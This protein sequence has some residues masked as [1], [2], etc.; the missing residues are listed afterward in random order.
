MNTRVQKY[1]AWSI[2]PFLGFYLF[3]F[4]WVAGFQPPPSPVLTGAQLSQ[5]YQQ[6]HND[7]LIGQL[8][9]IL[10][11]GLMLVWPAAVS[12]Q[13]ARIEQ[14]SF[15]L[16]SIIQYVSA[17]VLFTLFLL[18]GVIWSVAAFRPDISPDLLRLL[19]DS[20]WL[21][22]VMGYPEYVVQLGCIAIV[23]LSDRRAVPFLPRWAC[24]AMLGTAFDGCGGVFSALT[25]SGWF[26]WNGILGFWLPVASFFVLLVF[27][28][29]PFTLRAIRQEEQEGLAAAQHGGRAVTGMVS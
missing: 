13:M 1:C 17:S 3:G 20:G 7:I 26:A 16:L 29:L 28:I 11:S 25:Q 9:G 14:G 4:G 5:F 21:L 8:I 18:C 12:A 2:L 10:S 19:N 23:G 6:N 22:F 24:F 27:I 15:K